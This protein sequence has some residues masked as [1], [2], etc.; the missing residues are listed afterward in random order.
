[1]GRFAGISSTVRIAS[2]KALIF[3]IQL[4][5]QTDAFSINQHLVMIIPCEYIELRWDDKLTGRLALPLHQEP[6]PPR[7]TKC[8]QWAHINTILSFF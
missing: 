6:R 3:F 2:L 1:M 4:S 7:S 8:R 5:L